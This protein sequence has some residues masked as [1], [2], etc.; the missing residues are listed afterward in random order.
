MQ[1]QNRSDEIYQL[2]VERKAAYV[3]AISLVGLPSAK[4]VS[5]IVKKLEELGLGDEVKQIRSPDSLAN[6]KFVNRPQRLTDKSISF[7]LT[8]YNLLIFNIIVW[9]HIKKD[10]LEFME[11]M[12]AKRLEREY[13]DLKL[14][15]KG[16]AITAVRIFKKAN[17]PESHYFPEPAD[18]CKFPAIQA[19][20]EEPANATVEVS[21]FADVVQ[22]FPN[23]I[24]DWRRGVDEKLKEVLKRGEP[25][26]VTF[27]DL[28][29]GIYY[30]EDIDEDYGITR[31]TRTPK[32]IM[33][34]EEATA[35]LNLA[36]TVFECK[37]CDPNDD[38]DD[39]CPFAGDYWSPVPR[40]PSRPL[41][42]PQV[43]GHLLCLTRG[44]GPF[45]WEVYPMETETHDPSI[46]LTHS[47][48]F[49]K[50]RR[51]WF[52]GYLQFNKYKS[53]KAEAVV[54]AAGLDP[55][56]AT[57]EDMDGL[58]LRF[59]CKICSEEK[60]KEQNENDNEGCSTK[61]IEPVKVAV[62][63]YEWRAMVSKYVLCTSFLSN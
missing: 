52:G 47:A 2:K 61:P 63:L 43:I 45:S 36:A 24:A 7:P 21:S 54:K 42:Y 55:A 46:F 32:A 44:P 8:D 15:R 20:I 14:I 49:G 56:V 62:A 16:L 38:D 29:G 59:I 35:K 23:L 31:P 22:S 11:K 12:K 41:F 10:I 18:Y 6:H 57:T 5:S 60:K 28:F 34:D 9:S 19:I 53:T 51:P 58:K 30:D 39:C 25:P 50:E 4:F 33:S 27:S 48:G 37:K 26:A 13:K 1:T 17:H 3:I 40:A